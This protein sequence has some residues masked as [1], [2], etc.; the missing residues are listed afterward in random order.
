LHSLAK[1]V[2]VNSGLLQ[3]TPWETL[4][5]GKSA[6]PSVPT[7]AKLPLGLIEEISCAQGAITEALRSKPQTIRV[8]IR[9]VNAS[10]R[11]FVQLDRTIQ[12]E[13]AFPNDRAEAMIVAKV[14]HRILSTLPSDTHQWTV[15]QD[16]SRTNIRCVLYGC[17][18]CIY[19]TIVS[20]FS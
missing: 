20:V 6:M 18:M 15:Q 14:Q 16:R 2:G 4:I 11:I 12:C 10:A 7:Y 1:T 17:D 9:L 5:F 19:I 3:M 13:F 8:M